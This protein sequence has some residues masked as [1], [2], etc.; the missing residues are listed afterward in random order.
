MRFKLFLLLLCTTL[1]IAGCSQTTS[2]PSANAPQ[3]VAASPSVSSS[4]PVANNSAPAPAAPAKAKIDACALLTSKEIEAVQGEALQET[5]LSG[6]ST[7]GF[8]M[9]QCFFTLPTFTN[10]I[11]LLVAQKGDGSSAQDPREFFRE[12]FH[13]KRE[14]EKEREREREREKKKGREEEEEEG[15]PP[16]KVTGIGD[17]AYWTGSRV[18]GALYVLKGHSYVRISIGGPADQATKIKKTK[19]LAAKAIARL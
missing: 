18:G 5:K 15:S 6:Q 8:S 12:R 1:A 7:G 3:T 14:G 16:Q 19:A 9:S 13:E 11:S 4:S 10:S 17:E 2:Q